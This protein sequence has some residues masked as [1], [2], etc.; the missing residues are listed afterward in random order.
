MNP[1]VR[2]GPVVPNRSRDNV[3]IKKASANS[4]I[5]PRR[6]KKVVSKP[7]RPRWVTLIRIFSKN[8]VL[9]IVILGL[10][11]MIRK[12]ALKSTNSSG[13]PDFERRIVEVESFVKIKTNV[14]SGRVCE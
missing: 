8:L 10:V 5:E 14:G 7:V 2:L 13:V 1:M 3:Q 4:S 12:L 9:L 6:T 11:E